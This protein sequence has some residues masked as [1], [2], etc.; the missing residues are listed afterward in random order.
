MSKKPKVKNADLLVEA[1]RMLL[2]GRNANTQE[3]ICSLLEKQGYEINQSKVSRLLRKIGATK[4]VNEKGQTAYSLPR[5]PSPLPLNT[6]IRNLIL[7]IVANETLVVII[8]SPGA[9]SMIARSLD[10]SQL[11]TEILGTIAGDDTIF[12][13]PKSIKNIHK[14]FEEVKRLLRE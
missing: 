5:E 4:V 14:L 9:A 8:T 2:M 3:D 11:T 1:L 10:Y 13:A 7:D 12:I 6:S